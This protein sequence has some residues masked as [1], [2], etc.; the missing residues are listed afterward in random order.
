MTGTTDA[1]SHDG[2]RSR[3]WARAEFAGWLGA[4]TVLATLGL[5]FAAESVVMF[6]LPLLGPRNEWVEAVIDST[7]LTLLI[8]PFVAWLE[9][10][11]RRAER[12]ASQLAAIVEYA[13]DAVVGCTLDGVMTSWNAG[14]E[15]QTGYR[16]DEAIGQTPGLLLPPDRLPEVAQLLNR[17]ARG[18]RTSK[19]RT[20]VL[21]KDGTRLDASVSLAPVSGAHGH[22]DGIAVIARDISD[23][24]RAEEAQA[25]LVRDLQSALAEVRTL[26]GLLPICAACKKI[27]DD[28][29]YWNQIE[30]Y[31]GEHSDVEFSHG[32]CPE[33]A[34]R[35]YG[36]YLDDPGAQP[37]S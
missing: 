3:M 31:L 34:R 12:K 35:L 28:K 9:A 26:S 36:E 19:Y 33:C 24:V 30:V 16:A 20:V 1:T 2:S 25:A 32:V 6:F 21:R 5:V 11:R 13:E 29:G 8:V 22:I 7:I 4:R 18:E 23:L 27:R 10:R 15:R 14:A 17:V 37:A